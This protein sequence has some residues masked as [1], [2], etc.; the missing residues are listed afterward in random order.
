MGYEQ[1]FVESGLIQAGSVETGFN[2]K[3]YYHT[4]RLLK[5]AFCSLIQFRFKSMK[6]A[7][8]ELLSQ[9]VSLK[10]N[11]QKSTCDAILSS[12]AFSQLCNELTCVSGTQGKMTVEFLKDVSLV[13]SL[14]SAARDNNFDLHL[15]AERQMILLTGAYD[16]YHYTRYL[17]YQHVLYSNLKHE[18]SPEYRDLAT[19][20]FAASYSGNAFIPCNNSMH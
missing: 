19:K 6:G 11:T 3:K 5:A 2:G 13:L 1:R 7:D 18:S 14:I 8:F 4:M 9:I 17:T 20:G 16:H 10:S 12:P 15:Q